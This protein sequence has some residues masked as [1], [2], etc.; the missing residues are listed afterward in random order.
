MSSSSAR[1]V[2]ELSSSA[3]VFI[4]KSDSSAGRAWN[5]LEKIHATQHGIRG[6]LHSD[7]SSFLLALSAWNSVVDSAESYLCIYSHAGLEGIAPDGNKSPAS[8]IVRWNELATALPHG[9]R[10]LWL[11]GC[12]TQSVLDRWRELE[13]PV[14]HHLLVTTTSFYWQPFLEF[15]ALEISADTIISNDE[16]SSVLERKSPDLAK[17]SQFYDFD[18]WIPR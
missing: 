13:V 12:E 7:K 5:D 6:E 15:F 8:S 2:G 3:A 18:N 9:V 16:I 14:A 10:Y 1:V 11:L 17:H 4:Y